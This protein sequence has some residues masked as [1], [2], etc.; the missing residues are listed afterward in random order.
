MTQGFA[1]IGWLIF[2]YPLPR[3]WVMI[4]LLFTP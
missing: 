2:F 3:A 1:W 4:K